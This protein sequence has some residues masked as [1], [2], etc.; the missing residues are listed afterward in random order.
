MFKFFL[1]LY[2]DHEKNIDSLNESIVN[3]SIDLSTSGTNFDNISNIKTEPESEVD[4]NQT[5]VVYETTSDDENETKNTVKILRKKDVSI[6][7][8][9]HERQVKLTKTEQEILNLN[10]EI[11]E[12]D[13]IISNTKSTKLSDE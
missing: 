11:E 9:D 6:S 10:L 7:A 8:K 12:L 3:S 2:R 5:Y 1:E 4:L 13:Y